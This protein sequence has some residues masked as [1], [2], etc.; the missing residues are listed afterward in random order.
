MNKTLKCSAVSF[1]IAGFVGLTA[2][3]SG[4]SSGGGISGGSVTTSGVITGFGSVF[5]DGVEFETNT[6][7]YSLDD[8]DDGPGHYRH[9]AGRCRERSGSQRI[10]LG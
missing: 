9:Q 8:G 7:S 10:F 6:S 2:C 4:G 5:V 3:G 1:I